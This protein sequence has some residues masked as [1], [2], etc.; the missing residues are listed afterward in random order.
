MAATRNPDAE[1]VARIVDDAEALCRIPAP[2][3]AE[4]T[5]GAAVLEHL[6]ALHLDAAFDAVGNVVARIGED[7]PALALCAH[8]DTVFPADTPLAVRREHGRLIGPGI[9]D[10]A[11]GIATLLHVARELAVAP[12]SSPVL[13]GFTV[14]EEGLGD[15][16]GV[17]ALLDREPVRALIAIEGHGVDSLA[18]GG[19]ASIR[20][21][22]TVTGPGGHSWTDRG[23]PSA[24]HHLIGLGEHVLETARPAAVNIG[25]ISGG[26]AI[27][28][29]A[30]HAELL[31]DIRHDDQRVVEAAAARVERAVT[32]QPPDG[33]SVEL[34]QVGNRPG[35]AN[36]PGEPLVAL[37]HAARAAVGLGAAEEHLASTDA[38]AGLARGIPSLGVGIT[39][40]DHAHR[41]DEW[42]AEAPIA[43]GVGALLGLIR[44]AT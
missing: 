33:I 3:F 32:T 34:E 29:I 24:V 14:G 16:R 23:R 22:V 43:L 17:S 39:R 27:N 6:Q 4:R 41:T 36:A 2:T 28:A 38:N 25:T 15:L 13:L 18:V 26:T 44:S 19:I 5:R 10:N 8:L 35:G 7:G 1:A 20:Y 9:G 40:G 31:I 12:P 11:L 37:A 21:R 30:D 42:I